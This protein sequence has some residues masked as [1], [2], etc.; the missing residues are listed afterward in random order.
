MY[1]YMITFTSDLQEAA[2]VGIFPEHIL[3]RQQVKYQLIPNTER[4]YMQN[5]LK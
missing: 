1:I 4:K 2:M 5:S 3:V